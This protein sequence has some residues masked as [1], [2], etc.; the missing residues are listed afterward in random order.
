MQLSD[1][2][3][4]SKLMGR[5]L[6]VFPGERA[7]ADAAILIEEYF[8]TLKAYTLD[9]F[10]QAFQDAKAE[11]GRKFLPTP[12]ELIEFMMVAK[13]RRRREKE[14]AAQRRKVIDL[15]APLSEEELAEVRQRLKE[16]Y[17]TLDKVH[18]PKRIRQATATAAH[19]EPTAQD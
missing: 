19:H 17:A 6:L 5:I 2:P 7:A 13:E 9:E 11:P 4:F 15:T 1:K 3:E 18:A 10:A 14:E 8:E 12:G 16:L